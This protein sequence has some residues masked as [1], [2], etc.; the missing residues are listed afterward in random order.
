MLTGLIKLQLTVSYYLC[1]SH[2][3]L[4]FHQVRHFNAASNQTDFQCQLYS[5]LMAT[6]CQ[7]WAFWLVS[8]RHSMWGAM[9]RSSLGDRSYQQDLKFYS[10]W[11]IRIILLHHAIPQNRSSIK[12]ILPKLALLFTLNFFVSF[13]VR[14][15]EHTVQNWGNWDKEEQTRFTN[16]A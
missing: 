14:E 3:L 13:F 5:T 6:T 12:D 11:I 7:C 2:Q 16:V 8:D 1:T 4:L 10:L 15:S 9:P